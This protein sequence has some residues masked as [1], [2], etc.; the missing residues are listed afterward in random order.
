MFGTPVLQPFPPY[1]KLVF[2][3]L[4]VLV[5]L[6]FTL[7]AGMVFSMLIFGPGVIDELM[8]MTTGELM[9]NIP[10]QKYFQIVSQLGTFIFPALIFSFLVNRNVTGYLRMDRGPSPLT[11]FLSAG[12]ILAMMP[13]VS[14][15]VTINADIHLPDFLAGLEHWMRESED[16]AQKLTEAFLS[17]T[18]IKG[19]IINLFMIG[20]LAAVGEELIFRGIIVRLLDEWFHN[21]HLAVWISAIA[22]SALHL[23]FYGF[24][25]RMILGVMLGYLFIWSG[26]LWVPVIAH[27][28]NNGL[29]VMVMYFFSKGMISTNLEEFGSSSD[30]RVILIT[31]ILSAGM[32]AGIFL[33][34]KRLSH[35]R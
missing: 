17:D 21:K 18:S 12:A 24:L 9:E 35:H 11:L 5:T 34:E 7:L 14:W 31:S 28:I 13:F 27:L 4:L 10:L 15:L 8:S 2:L 33:Y 29:A 32:M 22:F 1:L 3:I 16:Q 25:P 6:L 30:V 20:I 23:Q 19:L 26:S